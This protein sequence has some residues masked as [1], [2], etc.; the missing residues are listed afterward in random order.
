MTTLTERIRRIAAFDA[1]DRLKWQCPEKYAAFYEKPA[2]VNTLWLGLD[3]D[4]ADK[5][6]IMLLL[7]FAEVEG[8]L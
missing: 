3:Y 5:Q 4:Y 7:W 6:R 8:Q 1:K 2:Q